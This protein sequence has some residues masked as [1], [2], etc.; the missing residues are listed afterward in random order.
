MQHLKHQQA[1]HYNKSTK[2]L[3]SLETGNAV[4]IQLV[5]NVRNWVPWTIIEVISAKSY[6]V[7]TLIGGVYLRN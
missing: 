5:P 4:H 1:K 3:P 6:K 2:D 7:K